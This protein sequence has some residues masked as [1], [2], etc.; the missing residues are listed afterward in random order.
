MNKIK[1]QEAA[2]QRITIGEYLDLIKQEQQRNKEF[3]KYIE[4]V[5]E[6]VK[7]VIEKL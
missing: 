5:K 1:Q 6:I 4:I 7:Q 3:K 2:K